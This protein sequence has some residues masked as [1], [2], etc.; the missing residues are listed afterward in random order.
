M[1]E[2][3][4]TSL[5]RNV[6]G[7]V[8]QNIHIFNASVLENIA[9]D[10]AKNKTQEVMNFLHQHGFGPFIDSL[11]QSYMT[12][13]GEEGVNLSGG[14]K[15]MIALARA[16]YFKPQLLILDE[17]TSAMDRLSEQFVLQLLQHLKNEMGIIFI[18]HRLHILR[19]FCDR[20]YILEKGIITNYGTHDMLLQTENMYSLYWNDLVAENNGSVQDI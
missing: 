19:S 4:N 16:L 14:Q 3:I 18:T 5:W 20:V 8:P 12:L 7:A 10:D 17:A 11:P 15:Q 1:L 2:S 9:F 13:V 6:I